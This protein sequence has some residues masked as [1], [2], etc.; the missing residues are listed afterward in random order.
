MAPRPRKPLNKD[1]SHVPN[2]YRTK[3][4]RTG[5]V[6]YQYLDQRTNKFRGLGTDKAQA[7]QDAQTLN[8]VIAQ[9][10]RSARVRAMTES[11]DS[12]LLSK[13]IEQYIETQEASAA[14][15]ELKAATVKQRKWLANTLSANLGHRPL[16][17]V[18]TLELTNLLKGIR[19][20]GNARTAQALRSVAIDIYKEA[21]AEG[22]AKVN[23]AAVTRY[24][25][26]QTQRARLV[27]ETFAAILD[28]AETLE[29]WVSNTL[30]LAICTAQR[31]EDL[32]IMQFRRGA[33]WESLFEAWGR[34]ERTAHPYPH[35]H[36]GRLWVVQQKTGELISIPLTLRLDVL[37]VTVG[38]VVNRCRD[39]VASRFLIHHTKKRTMSKPG[40]PVHVNT[41]SKGFRRARDLSGL[42]WAGK[43]PP[44][45]YECRSLAER[46]YSAQGGDTQ[47]L[48]GHK[49]GRMTALYHDARGAEWREVEI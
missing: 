17:D 14:A 4:K 6:Y 19:G 22:V 42:S 34:G 38:D 41:L 12:M 11:G 40:D 45:L 26:V 8:A 46:L 18:T 29:P 36:E 44:T 32:A 48:L 35:I 16:Q 10:I 49:H 33:D 37:G 5:R 13:W 2:L 28:K 20:A 3:D 30:L 31:P 24:T 23:P 15:G 25:K 27:W 39:R 1:L 47:T 7:I 21:I 43:E 9:A